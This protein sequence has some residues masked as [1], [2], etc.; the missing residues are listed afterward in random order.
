[1]IASLDRNNREALMARFDDISALYRELSDTYQKSKGG[2][3]IP[4]A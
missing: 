3:G 4:L 1:M 2:K